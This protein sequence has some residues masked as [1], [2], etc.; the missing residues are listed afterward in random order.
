[1]LQWIIS[2]MSGVPCL[3]YATLPSCSWKWRTNRDLLTVR[4]S[5]FS[6][7]LMW[8]MAVLYLAAVSLCSSSLLVRLCSASITCSTGQNVYQVCLT[9]CFLNTHVFSRHFYIQ[10]AS[11]LKK[12]SNRSSHAPKGHPGNHVSQDLLD[13][14]NRGSEN[15]KAIH[16]SETGPSS[17]SWT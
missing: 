3:C 5:F 10:Q 9:S 7:C 2:I 11:V 8:L 15:W 14:W 13:I 16:V 6:S 12:S 17:R 1:M 4:L